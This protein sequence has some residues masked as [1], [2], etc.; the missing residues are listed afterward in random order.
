MESSPDDY[1]KVNAVMG[2]WPVLYT[3]HHHR[4]LN[5]HFHHYQV[6]GNLLFC[7]NGFSAKSHFL[8]SRLQ[9]CF[10]KWHLRLFLSFFS[11]SM[12]LQN[13]KLH[14][15]SVPQNFSYHQ[16]ASGPNCQTLESFPL[17]Q[18]YTE[19]SLGHLW[20]INPLPNPVEYD[21]F[22]EY[23]SSPTFFYTKLPLL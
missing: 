21:Y 22:G 3:T 19:V 12:N 6:P 10:H 14:Y 1:S 9:L 8:L 18:L 13:W 2:A 23:F 16:H 17:I 7:V 11:S 15:L 4:L 5:H 20:L